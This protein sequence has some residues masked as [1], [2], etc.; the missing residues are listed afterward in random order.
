LRYE[1]K[2]ALIADICAEHDAFCDL[3]REIPEDRYKDRGFLGDEWTICDLVA[4]L[5]EWQRMF[6]RWYGE[7]LKGMRPRMPAP[8]YKWNELPKLNRLIRQK[9]S[10]RG[11]AEVRAYFD[12]GYREI[13]RLVEALSEKSLLRPEHFEWTGNYP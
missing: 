1:S 5:A 2:K 12:E 4:H 10:N 13:L 9:H 7:G 8:D 6:L 3:L 11:P